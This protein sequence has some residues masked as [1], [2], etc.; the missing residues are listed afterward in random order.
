MHAYLVSAFSA[1]EEVEHVGGCHCRGVRFSVL[2]PSSLRVVDCN[3]SICH[4]KRNTHFI[5]PANKFKLTSGEDLLVTYSFNTHQAK[6]KFCRIC[7]VQC[8]YIPR[9][10]PDGFAVTLNCLDPGTV[11]A[12][13]VVHF[14]G[15]NWEEKIKESGIQDWSK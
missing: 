11:T 5:V 9:S 7:G 6:H 3:C 10:N 12:T 2:A 1:M 13:E 14:D 8:F 15:K 4:M